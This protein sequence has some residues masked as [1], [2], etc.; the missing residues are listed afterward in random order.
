MPLP[1]TYEFC[2]RTDTG[3]VRSNNEDSVAVSRDARMVIVADGMGGYNAGE[4]ASVMAVQILNRELRNRLVAAGGA[5]DGELVREML[6][7]GVERANAAIYQA[8][9]AHAHYAGMGTT[10]VAGLFGD[11][12]VIIGHIGDSRAY[13]LRGRRLSRLTRDHTW[14]QEQ[15]DKGVMTPQQAQRSGMRSLLTRAIGVDP[16]VR[17]EINEFPVQD[18]DLFLFCSDGLTDSIDDAELAILL[19]DPLPLPRLAER[20]IQQ[21]NALG[22]RDNI[23]V[24]LV[25]AIEPGAAAPG[26]PG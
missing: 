18:A 13:L 19:R 15:V 21:G 20:L 24:L 26:D 23:S 9:K 7:T 10:L 8:A 22:G 25:R 11:E 16:R 1:L 17:L 3:R 4:V 14:L 12:R 5:A 2:A 6:A